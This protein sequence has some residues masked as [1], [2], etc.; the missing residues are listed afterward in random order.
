MCLSNLQPFQIEQGS[1]ILDALPTAVLIIALDNRKIIYTNHCA[2]NMLKANQDQVIDKH[3][4]EITHQNSK[5]ILLNCLQKYTR[6]SAHTTS[7][8]S[9]AL[10]K[11]SKKPDI[12]KVTFFTNNR[13][14][15]ARTL[16]QYITASSHP[17]LLLHLTPMA[18]ERMMPTEREQRNTALLEMSTKDSLTG[19]ANRTL[20]QSR[21][22]EFELRQAGE[23]LAL[24]LIDIDNFKSLNDLNGHY[25]GDQIL[26]IVALR[27]HR[28]VRE[29]DLVARIG[30]DEFAIIINHNP[31]TQRCHEVAQAII[32]AFDQPIKITDHILDI[33][34][35]VGGAYHS[36]CK[37][38]Q[39]LLFEHADLALYE[40]KREGKGRYRLFDSDLQ[41]QLNERQFWASR[42]QRGIK[43]NELTL[44]Y[45]PQTALD[46]G[47]LYGFEALL[48][49]ASESNGLISPMEIFPTAEKHNLL[50][51]IHEWVFEQVCQDL[52]HNPASF[53]QAK[54]ISINLSSSII[55]SP[56]INRLIAILS[57][58]PNICPQL[59]IEI[60][61][62][63]LLNPQCFTQLHA[64][65]KLGIQLALDDFGTGY[66][67]FAC[68]KDLPIDLLKIDRSLIADIDS[69]HKN[70]A[71]VEAIIRL[72]QALE[73]TVI[74]EGVETLA[75]ADILH[76]QQCTYMQGWL[77]S[78]A[79]PLE[80]L[81][82]FMHTL[83]EHGIHKSIYK[84]MH[85]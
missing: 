3:I 43:A 34:L 64:L 4:L 39:K 62:E 80:E 15:S 27:L 81:G 5:H 51:S 26:K 56:I 29:T 12:L 68:L 36:H 17:L 63:C 70:R 32:H 67:S 10:P 78:E 41:N 24:L 85:I 48:R 45:Q 40:S 23:P 47:Q 58:Y 50:G 82:S 9:S 37:D 59:V 14:V 83:A 31:S 7:L 13:P 49:W 2:L 18:E 28:T 84:G 61:E 71:I 55:N 33:S 25:I 1:S 79:L 46:S 6:T 8:T 38:S 42:L 72:T 65:K 77:V 11:T 54:H 30:G 53:S 69:D 52:T 57:N 75:E 16:A 20:F 73:I 21:L 19:V 44:H 66:S 74:A 35:S 60:T 22:E 76:Q